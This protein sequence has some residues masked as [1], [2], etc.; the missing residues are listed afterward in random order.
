MADRA[1][2]RLPVRVYYEDTDAGGIVY[3]S[4]YLKYAERGRTELLREAGFEHANLMQEY[5]A[6]FAVR[7]CTLDFVKPAVLD[8]AL[9]VETE[10]ARIRGASVEMRQKILRD[11][12]LVADVE[13]HVALI[14]RH[15]R[16]KRLPDPLAAAM[17]AVAPLEA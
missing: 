13:I 6:G 12:A 15:G 16:P 8:D 14:D 5:G 9:I 3:H 4:N 10:I 1:P 7:R 2:H 17:R 11:G